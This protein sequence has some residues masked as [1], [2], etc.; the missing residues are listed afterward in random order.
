[1]QSGWAVGW[2]AAPLLYTLLFAVLPDAT[3][4]RAMFFLGITPALLWIRRTIREPEVFNARRS[5]DT[6]GLTRAFSLLRPPSLST[7]LKVALMVTGAQGGCYAL[8][9]G[10]PTFLKTERHL[11]SLNAGSVR[12]FFH[13]FGAFIGFLAGAYL[14]DRSAASEASWSAPSAR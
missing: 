13:I 6:N 4:W 10:P 8:S 7:A 5:L 9:V 1:V 11:S 2:G 3:A 12:I 14:A